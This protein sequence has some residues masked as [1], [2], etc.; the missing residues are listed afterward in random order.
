MPTG[1]W[2][3]ASAAGRHELELATDLASQ[4][5]DLRVTLADL[6]DAQGY[7]D[8]TTTRGHRALMPILAV[9]SRTLTKPFINM[10]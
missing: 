2:C 7:G 6:D 5:S 8:L 4:V 3:A 1:S 9:S 10:K